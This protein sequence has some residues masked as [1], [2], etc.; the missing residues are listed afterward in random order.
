MI[1]RAKHINDFLRKAVLCTLQKGEDNAI[2]SSDLR[3]KINLNYNI[4][5]DYRSLT[6]AIETL[7]REGYVIISSNKGYYFPKTLDEISHYINKESKRARS[8]FY[9]IKS[10]KA[11]EKQML[12]AENQT[13]ISESEEI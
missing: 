9:T 1:Q 5:L 8:I 2:S 11:L 7:R 6:F 12:N 13:T 10:A 3:R 4:K